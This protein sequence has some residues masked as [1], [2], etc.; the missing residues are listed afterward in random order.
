MKKVF[1][2]GST[3][4]VGKQTMDVLRKYSDYFEVFALAAG[5]NTEE[6][7]RQVEEF[8]PKAV[9]MEKGDDISGVEFYRGEKG[10]VDLVKR[11]EIDIVVISSSGTN[12]FAPLI[13][14]IKQKK[15]ILIA[16]KES[17]IMAGETIND[18]LQEHEGELIPLD[19]EHSAIFECLKGEDKE[20]VENIILT[21]SGGPFRNHTK[22]QLKLVTKEEAV[23]HPVW[24]MGSKITVDSATL[25]NKGL[26]VIE[27]HHLF[28]FPL[29][30][31]KVVVHPE[32]IVHSMVEFKDGTIKAL[33]SAPD[34]KMPIQSALFY[35]QR[36]PK[37]FQKTAL[38]SLSFS[39]PDMEKF[40]CLKLAYEAGEKK[41]TAP[42]ALVF[43][44]EVVVN[45]FLKEE[46]SFF[47]IPEA[48]KKIVDSHQFTQNPTMEDILKLRKEIYERN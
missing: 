4:S 11:K 46:I 18:H 21:C 7:S 27:A 44:D 41:G 37:S 24:S 45:K 43:A 30:K 25:M 13:E 48:V 33:L 40:P 8:K 35:P 26:E 42:A 9:Y 36:A 20:E 10:L 15:K 1:V 29:E 23:N 38:N 2:L 28:Q 32:C 6:M 16:N 19:S 5:S 47:E 12:A 17:I 14:A 22:E 3:G 31:I 34:M 39:L